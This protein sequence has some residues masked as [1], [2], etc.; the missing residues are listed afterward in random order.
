M[1]ETSAAWEIVSGEGP[2]VAA[3]IHDGHA[4]R[5]GLRP[6][7]ALSNAARLTEEDPQTGAWTAVAETRVLGRRS[8]FEFDLNRPRPK[9]IYVHPADSWGL[10]VW[11]TELTAEM[12]AESLAHYDA[13]Y[14]DVGKLLAELVSRHGKVVVY[15]LHTYNHRRRGPYA[16]FEEAELNPEVNLGTGTMDRQRWAPVV[17][18]FLADLRGFDFLGRHLDVRENVKFFGGQFGKWIHHEFADS[19]CVL[20]IEFKK[21]FMDEWSGEVDAAQSAAT[22]AALAATVPG[23]VEQLRCL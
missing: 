14:L 1:P 15:D 16:E 3:A 4:V 5:E 10:K 21:F 8:R 6:L 18:R 17:E 9:A 20:S 13:F 23:V 2:I 12:I 19:V 11:N 7:L 22:Q